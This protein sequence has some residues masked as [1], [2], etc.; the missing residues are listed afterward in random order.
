LVQ[1]NILNNKY[2][3]I[4][5]ELFDEKT[6][7]YSFHT[8]LYIS[9]CQKDED[10]TLWQNQKPIIDSLTANPDTIQV[11]GEATFTCKASDPDGDSLTIEW[12]AKA[13]LFSIINTGKSVKWKAPDS[14][15]IYPITAFVTDG[16]DTESDTVF[17]TV[18]KTP[19]PILKT[20][21]NN[22]VDVSIPVTLEWEAVGAAIGYTLQ[23]STDSLFATFIFNQSGLTGTSQEISGLNYLTKYYWRVNVTNNHGTSEWS[24]T[25]QFVTLGTSPSAPLLLTPE[26]NSIDVSIIPTLTW[27]MSS[28]AISY[29]L[30]V[31]TNIMFT[32][33]V[34]NQSELTNASQ[35]LSGLSLLTQ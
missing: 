26:N 15:G 24:T 13:G 12:K 17:V 18:V 32:S 35:Q 14:V 29:T 6:F 5:S 8:F 25:F 10:P 2:A 7:T 21:T 19:Q 9:S 3:K 23:V 31:S 34:Y 27:N 16:K 4:F 20:P 28:G 22:A 1:I 33:F 11:N 30:Q